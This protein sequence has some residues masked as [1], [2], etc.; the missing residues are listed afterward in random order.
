M[1]GLLSHE[2]FGIGSRQG[3]FVLPHRV[4]PR[5]ENRRLGVDEETFRPRWEKNLDYWDRRDLTR[6][7][8]DLFRKRPIDALLHLVSFQMRRFFRQFR[9]SDGS[10]RE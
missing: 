2:L 5:R 8:S 4:K 10:T 1:L 7:L 3:G 6:A 9:R